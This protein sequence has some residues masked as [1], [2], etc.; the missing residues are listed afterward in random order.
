MSTEPLFE[1]DGM[2][3][4]NPLPNF[5]TFLHGASADLNVEKNKYPSLLAIADAS[6]GPSL[7]VT[8]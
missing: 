2:C 5:A 7:F 6:A 8:P 3:H 1:K 4:P